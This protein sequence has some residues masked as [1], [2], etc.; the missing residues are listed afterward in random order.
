M[1]ATRALIAGAVGVCGVLLA[2]PAPA[3]PPA[4]TAQ[5]RDVA[6]DVEPSAPGRASFAAC[7]EVVRLLSQRG[8][9][10][11]AFRVRIQA[12]PFDATTPSADLALDAGQPVETSAFMLAEALVERQLART[13]DPAVARM[14]A[15]A[16]AAHMTPP[17]SAAR[18]Q[19]ERSWLQRL[20]SGQ[21]LTTALPE[22]LWRNGADP[23]IRRASRGSWPESAWEALAALGIDNAL[24][25]VGEVAVAG[26]LDPRVLGFQRPPLPEFAPA[27]SQ[28]DLDVRLSQAGIRIVKLPPDASA[29]GLVPVE[30]E[31][32]EA[33]V[34]V[35]YAL[36]GAFDVVPLNGRAQVSVPMR[37]VAWAGVVVVGLE[38]DARLS[39]AVRA[40]PDY[41]VRIK[42]WDFVAGDTDVTLMWET[43]RHEG[44]QAFV[45]EAL[46]LTPS[47]TW[48]VLRRTVVPVASEGENPFGY[49]FVDEGN[50]NMA[51]YRLLA[52]TADGFLAEVGTFPLRAKQ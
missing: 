19:W 11:A 47:G 28:T 6:F 22:V 15:Q 20:A 21:I 9:E 37:G 3:A 12:N 16:V 18:V 14:L 8:W 45:V 25:P 24:H 2:A 35:R 4:L 40:L 13:A 33:W 41:P 50:E 38:P 5:V 49:T 39:L 29:V 30:S 44:L 46:A 32:V 52:L 36:T 23:A 10:T 1:N 26:L 17:G 43:Q 27:I 31:R 42:R 7:A 51:A 34:A 48:N